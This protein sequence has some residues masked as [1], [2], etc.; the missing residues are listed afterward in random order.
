MK[1]I[2][3]IKLYLFKE[4]ESVQGSCIQYLSTPTRLLIVFIILFLKQIKF[5]SQE[6]GKLNKK[7]F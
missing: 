5:F 3:W 7:T 4:F 1:K 6:Y 2:S